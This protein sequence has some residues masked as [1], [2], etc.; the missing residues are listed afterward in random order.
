MSAPALHAVSGD[1]ILG[2]KFANGL[3]VQQALVQPTGV[4][5]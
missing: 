4:A 2:N 5:C 1:V 3:S